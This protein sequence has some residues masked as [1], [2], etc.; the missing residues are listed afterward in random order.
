M[1]A[2]KLFVVESP[3]KIKKIRSL[4]EKREPGVWDVVAT[5]GHWRGLPPMAGQAFEDV[6]PPANRFRE[7][8]VV[9]EEKAEVAAR[10]EAALERAKEVFLASDADREG[11]AISW[12]VAEHFGLKAPK[13]VRANEITENGIWGAVAAAGDIDKNLVDAQRARA[14]LDYL[15]GMEMSRML[16]RFGAKSAGRLQSCA[17]RIIV[18]RERS[19]MGFESK[20]WW[21]L[22]VRYDEGFTATV[23]AFEVPGQDELDADERLVAEPRLVARR[24][25]TEAE[26]KRMQDVLC[27]AK[28][29]VESVETKPTRRNPPPPFTTADLL[30]T[31]SSRLGWGADKTTKVAQSLFEKGAITYI[32]TD[33]RALAEEAV[34]EIRSYLGAHHPS[35][36]PDNPVA[37]KQAATAQAA[38]EAIR[39]THMT[40]APGGELS[41]EEL[42]LYDIV[43]ERTLCCQAK[44]ALLD[45]TTIRITAG[46]VGL[47]AN[48][49][50]VRDP[51][52]T[53]VSSAVT[54][55]DDELPAV[56][57]GQSLKQG[58][59]DLEAGKT[60]PP[61]RF[62]ERALIKYLER[63]GIGRPSTYASMLSTLKE[64]EYIAE[65]KGSLVPLELG[66]L[67]DELVRLGFNELTQEDF[68][69]KTET[70]L[71]A[72]ADGKLAREVFLDKFY[73]RFKGL[74]KLAAVAFEGFA[75]KHPDRDRQAVIVHDKP[76][77]KCAGA[78]H[79]RR[80]P[81]G[82]Y[83][84]CANDACGGVLDLEPPKIHRHPCPK[85]GNNVIEQKYR[86]DGKEKH[87]FR[88]AAEGCDWKSGFPPPRVSKDRCPQCG[89]A[90]HLRRGP[91]SEFWSCSKYPEC[92]KTV[93]YAAGASKANS[94]SGSRAKERRGGDGLRARGTTPPSSSR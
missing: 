40:K 25:E 53:E 56:A 81:S 7:T 55:E 78:M 27:A 79:V 37:A 43:F 69:A 60:R 31:A 64:R 2:A 49:V 91:K 51:G 84:K 22:Q 85:C 46:G 62:T 23:G 14:L 83:A 29:V 1:K 80:G 75:S 90:M 42:E 66:T 3:N 65:Q 61:P 30:G 86:R 88:C 47:L 11:E 89:S 87:F 34:S 13:R 70:A 45:K 92:K 93:P 35:L 48:G 94:R 26:A 38:H 17:L 77:P 82:R 36:L 39:P 19:I 16:W 50:V 28:H 52:W 76:C 59:I 68:T 24:F 15:L 12:H 6:A 58:G 10:L 73:A 21:R 57:N 74:Q 33:S 54:L 44:S 32:R 4:L 63:R 20:P 18:D 8:F 71:D 67:A 41:A 72:I 9:H 5:V